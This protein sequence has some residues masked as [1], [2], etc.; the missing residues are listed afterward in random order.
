MKRDIVDLIPQEYL[1][2]SGGDA[3][4]ENVPRAHTKYKRPE[5]HKAW[6]GFESPITTRLLCPA[7]HLQ[8]LKEDPEG[9]VK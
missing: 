6:R 3:S 5:M 8:R 4:L 7:N 2:D 1:P 9:Y